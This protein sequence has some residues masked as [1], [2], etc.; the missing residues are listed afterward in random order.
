VSAS[1]ELFDMGITIFSDKLQKE[2]FILRY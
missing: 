2:N 1:I